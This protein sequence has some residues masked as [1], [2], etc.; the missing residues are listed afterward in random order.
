MATASAAMAL[1]R[2]TL[3]IISLPFL[4]GPAAFPFAAASGFPH[5]Y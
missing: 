4:T 1:H 2:I 3:V 5:T